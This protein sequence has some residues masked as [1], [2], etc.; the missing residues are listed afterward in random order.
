MKVIISRAASKVGE[1]M[2]LEYLADPALVRV[3]DEP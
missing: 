3:L 1:G 2:S